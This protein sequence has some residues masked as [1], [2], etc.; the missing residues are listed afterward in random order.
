MKKIASVFIPNSLVILICALPLQV[1]AYGHNTFLPDYICIGA[2]EPFM[3]QTELSYK[4]DIVTVRDGKKGLYS[5]VEGRYIIEMDNGEGIFHD[6]VYVAVPG[7]FYAPTIVDT[8]LSTDRVFM[9][10]YDLP[11]YGYLYGV[12]GTYTEE[13]AAG[14]EL[15][16]TA[17]NILEGS[18]VATIQPEIIVGSC[19]TVKEYGSLRLVFSDAHY[20]CSNGNASLKTANQLMDIPVCGCDGNNYREPAEAMFSAGLGGYLFGKCGEQKPIPV[21]LYHCPGMVYLDNWGAHQHQLLVLNGKRIV[22]PRQLPAG[23]YTGFYTYWNAEEQA[24]YA[25]E[26]TFAVVAPPLPPVIYYNEATEEL[27]AADGNPHLQWYADSTATWSYGQDSA[28]SVAGSSQCEYYAEIYASSYGEC[29]SKLGK[30]NICSATGNFNPFVSDS[31]CA[32]ETTTLFAGRGYVTYDWGFPDYSAP[33]ITLSGYGWVKVRVMDAD[34]KWYADSVFLEENLGLTIDVAVY[35]DLP[36]ASFI[37]LDRATFASATTN[38]KGEWGTWQEQ[39]GYFP[40]KEDYLIDSVYFKYHYTSTDV[41]QTPA[42]HTSIYMF[43]YVDIAKDCFDPALINIPQGLASA[44]DPVCGCNGTTYPSADAARYLFGIHSLTPGACASSAPVPKQL[45]AQQRICIPAGMATASVEAPSGYAHY[46]WDTDQYVIANASSPNASLAPGGHS[47][48][49]MDIQ[50]NT[51]LDSIYVSATHEYPALLFSDTIGWA[52]TLILEKLTGKNASIGLNYE[53]TLIDTLM[54]WRY[55]PSASERIA[56]EAILQLI[57]TEIFAAC[58]TSASGKYIISIR[59][60]AHCAV[61][62]QKTD[63]TTSV[64]SDGAAWVSSIS[65]EAP[66]SYLWSN[67]ST[68]DRIANLQAG[69]YRVTVTDKYLCASE[70]SVTLSPRISTL[71]SIAGTVSASDTPVEGASVYAFLGAAPQIAITDAEGRFVFRHVVPGTYRFM[72]LDARY[73]ASY[74]SH[75]YRWTDAHEILADTDIIGIDISM[76]PVLSG[77][78]GPAT[79]QGRIFL[80]DPEGADSTFAREGQGAG[81]PLILERNGMAVATSVSDADGYYRFANIEAGDYTVIINKPGDISQPS[82]CTAVEGSIQYLDILAETV[83]HTQT[84]FVGCNIWIEP[85]PA[86]LE[87]RIIGADVRSVTLFGTMGHEIF[88]SDAMEAYQIPRLAPGMY[89]LQIITASGELVSAQ[90]AVD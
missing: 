1:L 86:S 90:L 24:G 80:A 23:D 52:D 6:T 79:V 35:R 65:G 38:G 8:I 33:S 2:F 74:Y 75:A 31:I 15:R 78:K 55:V 87:F 45:F 88:R 19:Q 17:Y 4:G 7:D 34:G 59:A 71:Y 21:S 41:C 50:G 84:S 68:D 67:G 12:N 89:R 16:F 25:W 42:S 85:N 70:H 81:I 47:L 27:S 3:F 54:P 46:F 30:I 77:T 82:R 69:I 53:G 51:F 49:V 18:A 56:G 44:G 58:T 10:D 83:T 32:G 22:N 37:P 20:V 39:Y 43:K 14:T 60:L 57:S 76:L 11:E 63:P 36:A 62:V 61:T 66:F 48:V 13:S 40:S 73:A 5:D 64:S 26:G 9:Q 72:A 28:L 29:Y